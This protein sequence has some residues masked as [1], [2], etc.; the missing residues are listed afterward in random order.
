MAAPQVTT[1]LQRILCTSWATNPL[2]HPLLQTARSQP[3]RIDS[4]L[5][6]HLHE[7]HFPQE[8]EVYIT[9]YV[10][11]TITPGLYG[12]E[13]PHRPPWYYANSL[14]YGMLLG[15]AYTLLSTPVRPPKSLSSLSDFPF[16][17][18]PAEL[19]LQIY[20]YYKEVS[21]QR[22]RYW[23]IMTRIFLKAL[24]S[25][26]EPEEGSRYITGILLLT[27]GH[28]L[29]STAPL[30]RG[31][32]RSWIWW[33]DRIKDPEHTWGW[34]ELLE[35]IMKTSELPRHNTDIKKLRKRWE[36]ARQIGFSS[37]WGFSEGP[38][39]DLESLHKHYEYV[40]KEVLEVM[41]L[42]REHLRTDERDW[43]PPEITTKFF[44]Q[45]FEGNEEGKRVWQATGIV[46]DALE[47]QSEED[48]AINE[49][50]T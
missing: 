21:A 23:V 24:W 35:A 47:V 5:R 45:L 36:E 28:A 8:L 10:N 42:A 30:L 44:N 11:I 12:D 34:Q 31:H 2:L 39:R 4:L 33:D 43:T 1:H 9:D 16:P 41:D 40:S 20:E 22:Q 15:R 26:Y 38:G 3:S 27:C 46:P 7:H 50:N 49:A 18:L 14:L 48:A 32:G 13:T 29:S 6:P 19:R 17:K 25:G 37:Y